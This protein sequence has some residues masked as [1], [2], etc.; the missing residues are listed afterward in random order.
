MKS[1]LI[2]S[3]KAKEH[4]IE[5]YRFKV[6]GQEKK[7][8]PARGQDSEDQRS[9]A[10]EQESSN[11]NDTKEQGAH[12]KPESSFIEELLKRTDEMSGNMIKLQ[13]QIENQENEFAKRLESE[14]QRAKEDGIRQGA[15][16]AAAKFNEELKA[17]ESRYLGS[18]NKLEEQAAKFENLIVS[19]EAQLPTTAIEI[20]KE[21]VKK[22]IS[23]NSANIAAAICKELFGEIKDA[24]E[25]QVKVNP[26]DYE[27]IKENFSG[28]NVKISADE[29]ISAG[30]AIVLS[31]A[32]N[33]EGTIEARLEKIK[34][35]IGQ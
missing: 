31:D 5:N 15:E 22:E 23:L 30:G 2:S 7:Q 9:D 11:L 27:F 20:A 16:E 14:I 12:F 10:G 35:I 1:S 24:K 29:A 26:K 8:D 13:M 28:Q 21:V 32:G 19:S 33:L 6:L 3:E 18:I 34:K 25:V 17:L 4:F